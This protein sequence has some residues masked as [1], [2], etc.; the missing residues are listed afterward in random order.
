MELEGCRAILMAL[1]IL[2]AL[3]LVCFGVPYWLKNW[4]SGEGFTEYQNQRAEAIVTRAGNVLAKDSVTY[5]KYCDRMDGTC[6]PVE[7][8]DARDLAR[9]G[10]LTKEELASR[11]PT[12]PH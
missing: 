11:L 2:S 6:D 9:A 5:S 7:Y 12:R 8:H 3:I 10:N 1:L 4:W